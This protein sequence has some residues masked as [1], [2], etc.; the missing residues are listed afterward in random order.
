MFLTKIAA[1]WTLGLIAGLGGFLLLYI[2]ARIA[3]RGI[4]RKNLHIRD[5]NEW[6]ASGPKVFVERL[7]AWFV[8]PV[9]LLLGVVLALASA[10]QW[11]EL[12]Q[13]FY[14]TPFGIQDPIFGRDVM[15]YVFTIPMVQGL[16]NFLNAIGWLALLM[17]IVIYV[18]RGDVGAVISQGRNPW[19]FF[20]APRSQMHL[21]LRMFGGFL[22]AGLVLGWLMYPLPL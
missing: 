15:Y 11:R 1:Q 20:M 18:A 12:A 13:F 8:L 6:A 2:N 5:A 3:L 14:R 17:T 10:G 21:G 9:T 4:S 16:L 7:A 22:A 19:R